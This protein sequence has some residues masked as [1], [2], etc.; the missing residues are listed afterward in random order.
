MNFIQLF[1]LALGLSMDASAVSM[2]NGLADS[3]IKFKKALIIAALFGLFQG[4]MPLI[5]YLFGSIFVNFFTKITPF[6]A[7][8][9]L[10]FI[11]IKMIAEAFD[12]EKCQYKTLTAKMLLLQAVATSID[13]LAVGLVFINYSFIIAVVDFSIISVITFIISLISVYIGRKFGC[14]FNNKAQIAGGIILIIIGLKIFFDYI[15]AYI[16]IF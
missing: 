15:S 8:V 10:L 9:L 1:M 2:T 4:G 14:L 7:L 13:A 5:G 6:L 11:G 16:S 3:K 12:K